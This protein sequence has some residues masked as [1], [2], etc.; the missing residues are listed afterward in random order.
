[1]LTTLLQKSDRFNVQICKS[2]VVKPGK[3]MESQN[4]HQL[5]EVY[6]W[7]ACGVFPLTA[8]LIYIV[9]ITNFLYHSSLYS[10]IMVT[11]RLKFVFMGGI[12]LT[13][14]W[15][16]C[17]WAI[18]HAIGPLRL[19]DDIHCIFVT[20][21]RASLEVGE[22]LTTGF[23]NTHT[24]TKPSDRRQTTTSVWNQGRENPGTSLHSWGGVESSCSR[25]LRFMLMLLGGGV[26]THCNYVHPVHQTAETKTN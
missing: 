16:W 2:F 12:A 9:V 17:S 21:H 23:Q 26:C 20:M 14:G 19:T 22:W 5:M 25:L 7:M 24:C 1:M 15:G 13:E 3:L 10:K 4:E 18:C 6:G 11:I 8:V